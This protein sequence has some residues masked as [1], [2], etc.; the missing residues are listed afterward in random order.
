MDLMNRVCKP[1]LDKFVIVFIDDIL[2][3]SKSKQEHE[4]HLKLILELLKK[5]EL[6]AKFSKC[7][8]WIPKVQFLGYVIDRKANVVA[9]ALSRK[10]RIKPLRVRAL[11]MT[12]GL[13]LPKQI[14]EA[15]TEVK[16]E[17]Q[18][19][20]GLLVQQEIPQWK[21]DKIIM[22]FITKLLRTSS[23]YDTIWG[24][25]SFQKALGTRMEMSTAYHPQTNG[26][27]K[28]T[29]QTLEDMLRACV[30]D[31]GTSWDR[32]LP[33]IE[34]SYNNSY[35]ASIKAAPFEL[36]GPEIIHEKTEKIVQIK[37]RIQA[38]RDQKK[39]YADVKRKPLEFQE[40]DKVMLKVL[41][42]VGTVAYR[43]ELPQQLSRV[44]STFHVSNLKKCLSDKTS[45]I[46]LDEIH[47]DDKLHFVEEPVEIMDREVKR[48]RFTGISIDKEAD[49]RT[50]DEEEI[51]DHSK[52]LNGLETL[53]AAAQLKFDI[54]M[55][56]KPTKM[57][58]SFNNIPKAQVLDEPSDASGSSSFDS[59]PLIPFLLQNLQINKQATPAALR[60]PHV[61]STV[62]L[63]P[64]TTTYLSSQPPP[65]QLKRIKIKQ[66]MKKSHN[67]D[68]QANDT[69]L[70]NRVYRLE[71]KVVEMSKFDIQ[72]A[73]EKSVKARLKEIELPKGVPDFK[74]IKLEKAVKQNV[75]KTS[76]NKSA[77]S[78][79]YQKS[80]LYRMMKEVKA[81]N[82]HSAHK[83][84]YDA[85]T[86]SLSID[87]DDMDRIF[88]K[89][90]QT[91]S[92]RDD[93]DKDPSPNAD[94][95]SKKRQKKHDS[96][97]NDKDQVGTS[98]QCKSSSKPSIS[99][100]PVDAD[101]VIQDVETYPEECVEDAVHD[102]IP[103]A[104]IINKTTWFKQS[105]RPATPESPNLNWIK[106]QNANRGPSQNWFPKLK[107]TAK[108]PKY[109]DDVVGSTFDFSNFIKYRLNKDTLT[110]ADLEGPVFEHF[111]GSCRSCIELEH[112]LEQSYLAFSDN[113]D[114]TNPEGDKIP[115][116]FSKPLP[117]LNAHYRQYIP[118]EFFFNPDLEYLRT[119]NLE[120]APGV[121]RTEQYTIFYK[122]GGVTYESRNGKRRLMQ[123]D[124]VYMPTR[125]WLSRDKRQAMLMVKVLEKTLHRRQII[126]SLECYVGGRTHKANYRL[127]T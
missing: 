41:A 51:F 14:L 91:K 113:I 43:L 126:R 37:Q 98:K 17:H 123:E 44:H 20:S 34:F 88:G 79:Y 46:P 3:Y 32:H 5:E 12:I 38:A 69:S 120:Q 96:S 10:E 100:K 93:H 15:Q 99:N 63:I 101:E 66:M 48:R 87:E 127:L 72:A 35:H 2:I 21:W 61:D 97:K 27:S 28:R 39:S 19:P 9:D 49:Q 85:L 109:F 103:T 8:F 23:G 118:V 4:E 6:Y 77:T 84:F 16:A 111:K 105:P 58:S 53:S 108:A 71:R 83:A 82:S 112:H 24:I 116:D 90:H 117:L 50:I 76:W 18:K 25:K 11:V 45:T 36:T 125:P 110:K 22:G 13:D 33:L 1:H 59:A 107:K 73:I 119:G 89:S 86:V 92:R 122:P 42:K 65:R 70:K 29:I 56:I 52:K 81:F 67:P 104:P 31:F 115:Q 7:E 75:P 95:D 114:W 124:K 74:K 102:S 54:K 64:K 55:H 30:I 68:S 106:D 26:Q 62:T 60:H 47:I 94:K 78:I 121:D 40:G 57:T 80:R